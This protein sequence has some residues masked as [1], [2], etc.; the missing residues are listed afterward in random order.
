MH[1]LAIAASAAASAHSDREAIGWGLLIAGIL[2]IAFKAGRTL[3]GRSGGSRGTP[4]VE[5]QGG[6]S[7]GAW[8]AGIFLLALA[9]G[10]GYD[11]AS[12]HPA[13]HAATPAPQP[14]RT[15]IVNHTITQVIHDAPALSG[16]DWV[17]I[18]LIVAIA[19]VGVVSLARR[20][21]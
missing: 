12:T 18:V 3:F 20:F 11:R 15:V 14:T 9:C 1:T 19:A 6:H 16:T 2:A 4:V 8:A 17:L 13:A 7:A 10:Y 5:C 21:F